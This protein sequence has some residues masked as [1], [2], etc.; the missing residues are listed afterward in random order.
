MIVVIKLRVLFVFDEDWSSTQG[1]IKES[2]DFDSYLGS[3]NDLIRFE[4]VLVDCRTSITCLCCVFVNKIVEINMLSLEGSLQL[5]YCLHCS[6]DQLSWLLKFNY[7]FQLFFGRMIV[8]VIIEMKVT[9]LTGFLL[10]RYSFYV[11][12]SCFDLLFSQRNNS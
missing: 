4:P 8:C 5:R 9:A 3:Q 6:G 7:V 1:L 12:V 10:S 2:Q 11:F